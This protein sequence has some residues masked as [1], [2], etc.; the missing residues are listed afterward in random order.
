MP[1]RSSQANTSPVTTEVSRGSAQVPAKPSITSGPAQPV[2]CI[3]RPKRVSV[4]SVLCSP[5]PATN[6]AGAIQQAGTSTRIR[7]W[8]T[9]LTSSKR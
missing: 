9:S 3:Q 6:S 1:S 8:D 7:H 5:T 2:A 4:G